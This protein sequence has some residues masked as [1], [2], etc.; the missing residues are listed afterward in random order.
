M[1]YKKVALIP[2]RSG[3]KRVVD[4]NIKLLNGHPLLAYTITAAK[5][6]CIFDDVICATD[7][8]LYAEIAIYY[9]AEVPSLRPHSISG[10]KS[11]DIEWVR[12]ILEVLKA[13]NRSFDIFSILRPTSPFRLPSTIKRAFSVF[14]A[15]LGADSLRAVALCKQHPGK[16]WVIR[17]S[18]LLPILPYSN[19]STPWHSSQYASLPEIYVQDASLEIGWVKLPLE[20]NTI[21]GESI[22]PFISHEQEGFDIN[23]PDDWVLAENY[24]KKNISV[25]PEITIK[26]FKLKS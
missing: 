20:K 23:D 15:N 24:L 25:L 16:M 21:A 6:S 3:S 22:I 7:S 1:T 12:W 18:R 10:D 8:D 13:N 2:A 19:G 11:P 26:P 4:K 14:E 5:Q 9:G 17:G